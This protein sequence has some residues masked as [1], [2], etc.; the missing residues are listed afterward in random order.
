MKDIV[1]KLVALLLLGSAAFNIYIGANVPVLDSVM[2]SMKISSTDSI[3]K[4][5]PLIGIFTGAGLYGVIGI[6]VLFVKSIR[7]M[8]IVMAIMVLA[9]AGF[10]AYVAAATYSNVQ[11]EKVIDVS[12]PVIG[13]YYGQ[14]TGDK[15]KQSMKAVAIYPAYA[16][17]VG[18]IAG[19]LSGLL[20]FNRSY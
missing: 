11:I 13:Q 16:G 10:L 14:E 4:T 3:A 7:S 6:L 9:M 2:Q 17:I 1:G 19:G 18:A 8:N 15:Y 12:A 20:L 5:V